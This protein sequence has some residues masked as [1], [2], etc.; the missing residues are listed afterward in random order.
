MKIVTQNL[1]EQQQVEALMTAAHVDEARARAMLAD[2]RWDAVVVDGA[3]RIGSAPIHP[4]SDRPE[5]TPAGLLV[6]L[7]AS[8]AYGKVETLENSMAT[9]FIESTTGR[10]EL[11]ER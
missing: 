11:V 1:T 2:R 4:P 9:I 10:R 3:V 7:T 5:S 6:A 8:T